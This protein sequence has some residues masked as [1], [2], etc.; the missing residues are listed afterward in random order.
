MK[1]IILLLAFNLIFA[2]SSLTQ[3]LPGKEI[4]NRDIEWDD[5]SGKIDQTSKWDAVTNWTTLYS[6]PAPTFSGNSAYINISV[7]LFL[8]SD[9]WVKPNKKTDRLLE[10]E[11]GHFNIG[12]ICANEIEQTINST[13]FDRNSY[14]QQVDALYWQIIKKYQDLNAEYE[15]ETDHYNNI[16]QQKKWNK[17]LREMLR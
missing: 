9:S 12:R 11:R 13:A 14:H 16:A 8:K 3:S 5:F 2:L 6:F 4:R 15:R 7:R 10:H 17:K 1:K